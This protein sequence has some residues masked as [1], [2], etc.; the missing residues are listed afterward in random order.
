MNIPLSAANFSNKIVIIIFFQ[1]IEM[2]VPLNLA[3]LNKPA[4]TLLGVINVDVTI[5]LEIV[6]VSSKSKKCVMLFI[7]LAL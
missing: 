7:E 2:N 1:Q 5:L 4:S 3:S 6:L